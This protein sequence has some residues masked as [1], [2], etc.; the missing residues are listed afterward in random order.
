MKPPREY[1]TECKAGDAGAQRVGAHWFRFIDNRS[2]SLMMRD[3][4]LKPAIHA[5]HDATD[6]HEEVIP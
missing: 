5:V 4:A 2:L 3:G 6:Y 1:F